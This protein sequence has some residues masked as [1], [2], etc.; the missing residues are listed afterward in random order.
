MT[1]NREERNRFLGFPVEPGPPRGQRE[2]QQHVMGF[3]A[4]WFEVVN[5]DALRSLALSGPGLPAMGP[6]AVGWVLMPPTRTSR[7]LAQTWDPSAPGIL[8]LPSGR[9][10]RGRGL[11]RPRPDGPSPAFGVYLLGRGR[12][13]SP[14]SHTGSAGRISACPPKR[15][16]Y[17]LR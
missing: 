17:C 1:N 3:P 9:L 7:S 6:A 8:C 5:L 11:G 14:G 15:P 10:V 2:E 4:S 13:P 16:T 12:Q